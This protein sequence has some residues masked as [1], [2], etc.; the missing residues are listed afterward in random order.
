[1]TPTQ[2][3]TRKELAEISGISYDE[4]R[5]NEKF[6]GLLPHKIFISEKK[7]FK[8]IRDGALLAL[9]SRGFLK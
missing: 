5:R 8:F 2:L 4:I 9:K 6:L 7:N 1:M 3:I